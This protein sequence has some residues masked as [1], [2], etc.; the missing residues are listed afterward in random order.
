MIS[1]PTVNG[2]QV[3]SSGQPLQTEHDSRSSSSSSELCG[4]ALR[5]ARHERGFADSRPALSGESAATVVIA[6]SRS[7]L[8]LRFR[9]VTV[10][11]GIDRSR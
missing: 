4:R 3:V 7:A 6:C 8:L 1:P 11:F 2:V 5:I 10:E 9:T